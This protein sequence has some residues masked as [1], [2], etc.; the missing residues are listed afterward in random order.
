MPISRTA[1]PTSTTLAA[2]NPILNTQL[3]DVFDL[4]NA[5]EA[6]VA[7]NAAAIAAVAPISQG[8]KYKVDVSSS[9]VATVSVTADNLGVYDGSTWVTLSGVNVGSG[10]AVSGAYGLDT[11]SEAVSTWYSIWVIYDGST[12]AS[13]LSVSDGVTTQPTMPSGYTF[14][15]RV[16]WVYNDSGGDFIEFFYDNTTGFVSWSGVNNTYAAYAPTSSFQAL[17]LDGSAAGGEDTGAVPPK[18]RNI[19]LSVFATWNF[20]PGTA[21]QNY[22]WGIQLQE[23][24]ATELG[25]RKWHASLNST[26]NSSDHE[27]AGAFAVDMRCDSSRRIEYKYSDDGLQSGDTPSGGTVAFAPKVIG[28]YDDF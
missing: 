8:Q 17:S 5:N 15:R 9:G 6:A 13:L 26:D 14:K 21:N 23:N 10:I 20:T 4:A 22:A 27:I 7:T 28:W 16:G 25:T 1:I 19:R 2:S 24:G 18:I 12:T 3:G 11:G